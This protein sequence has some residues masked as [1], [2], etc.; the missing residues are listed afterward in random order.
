V[1]VRTFSKS[2]LLAYRQCPK[3]LWLEIHRPELRAD[4]SAT[5]ASFKVGHKVGA[6]VLQFGHLCHDQA[7]AVF[8]RPK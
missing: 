5:Q 1:K 4:S 7:L 3:R 8:L 2:K 6:G